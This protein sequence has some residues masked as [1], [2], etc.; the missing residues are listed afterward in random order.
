VSDIAMWTGVSQKTIY[1]IYNLY[2]KTS[3]V[4]PRPQPGRKSKLSEQ[5]LVD[6][7]QEIISNN[8]ITLEELIDKLNLPIKK[9][10]LSKIIIDMGFSYIKNS[11]PKKSATSRCCRKQK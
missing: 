8:D 10:R 2:K 4:E 7:K 3:S 11:S 9:S 6:I 5:Q 1:N